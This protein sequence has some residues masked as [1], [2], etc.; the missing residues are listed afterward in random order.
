LG[1]CSGMKKQGL[2]PKGRTQYLEWKHALRKATTSVN[3]AKSDGAR[4][5]WRNK[6]AISKAK[7]EELPILY[8]YNEDEW[9]AYCIET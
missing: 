9:N 7:L 4:N 8:P 3:N 6:A 1:A 2:S 5:A